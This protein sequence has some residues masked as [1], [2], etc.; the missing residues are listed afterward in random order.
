MSPALRWLARKLAL[1]V[2]VVL[3]A[4]TVAFAALHLAPGDPVR[5]VIG[6]L[7]PSDDLV[8]QVRADLDLDK[9]LAT[10]YAHMLGGLARGDLGESYQLRRPV[11]EVIVADLGWTVQLAV[12]SLLLAL[13]VST[14]LAVATAGRR[15][16]LRRVSILLELVTASSPT[17]WVG[18]ILLAVLSFQLHLF[19]AAGAG[20]LEGLVLP[21]VTQAIGLVGI[22]TQVLRQSMEQA[23]DEP[24]ALSARARGTTE[25][26]LRLRHAARH[27]LIP[28]L[29]LSG[30]ILGA[31]LSG[32]VVVE[33]LFS[34]PGLGRTLVTAILGRDLPV[35]IGVVVVAA[36]LFTVINLVVDLLY[37]VVDPR[38]R[39]WAA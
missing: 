27:A 38:L 17:F 11:V 9:P 6:T 25:T 5:A 14:A 30:W 16:T 23:L 18:T 10:Q 4:A 22:F 39:E 32:A 37:R 12:A 8:A 2:L 15:P 28:V 19:P 29:T 20:G 33:T 31:L 7:A 24:F 35:V 1:A 3:G 26:A 13:V 21:A 36:A 34:R